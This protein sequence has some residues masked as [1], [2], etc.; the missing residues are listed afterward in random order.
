VPRD[1][2][3]PRTAE[4]W[5]MPT[6]RKPEDTVQAAAAAVDEAARHRPRCSAA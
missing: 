2:R 4:E 6:E 3:G 5:M 1:R